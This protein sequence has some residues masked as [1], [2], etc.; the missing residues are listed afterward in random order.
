MEA[1]V[2]HRALRADGLDD[3]DGAAVADRVAVELERSHASLQALLD[4]RREL[5]AHRL[6]AP[7]P[8]QLV[9]LE[10]GQRCRHR[11][12]LRVRIVL[13]EVPA[14]LLGIL[15]GYIALRHD[16]LFELV[17]RGA[18]ARTSSPSAARS[19]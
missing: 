9:S 1:E 11:H 5:V 8:L 6:L 7:L 17:S 10:G 3:L 14:S 2:A 19:S 18:R 15:L 12:A 4:R 13:P 16:V